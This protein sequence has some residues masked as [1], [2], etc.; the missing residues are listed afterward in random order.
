MYE[1]VKLLHCVVA[2]LA[3]LLAAAIFVPLLRFEEMNDVLQ[4]VKNRGW[5]KSKEEVGEELEE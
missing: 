3:G 1:V 2:T 4:W 5:K